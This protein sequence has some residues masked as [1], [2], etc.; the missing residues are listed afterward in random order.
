MTNNI[1]LKQQAHTVME[2]IEDAVQSICDEHLISG[3]KVWVMIEGLAEAK[4][5][6]FPEYE[7]EN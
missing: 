6:Q 7:E 1:L 4:L 2:V 3:E 5:Q